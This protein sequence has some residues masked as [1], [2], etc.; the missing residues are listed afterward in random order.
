MAASSF[1]LTTDDE[2]L[3]ARGYDGRAAR[4]VGYPRIYLRPAGNLHSTPRELA[5]LRADAA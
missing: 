5:P 3:L 4:P 2:A 1:H